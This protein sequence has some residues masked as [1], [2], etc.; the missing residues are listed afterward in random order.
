[1]PLRTAP[2]DMPLS[3][4]GRSVF[5]TMM[6][7]PLC[8]CDLLIRNIIHMRWWRNPVSLKEGALVPVDYI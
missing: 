8:Y 5:G 7:Y 2:V 4:M 3:K 6:L 1:M